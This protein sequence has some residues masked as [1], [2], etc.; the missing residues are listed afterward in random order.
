[1]NDKI[2][3]PSIGSASIRQVYAEEGVENNKDIPLPFDMLDDLHACISADRKK[4]ALA[5]AVKY[6]NNPSSNYNLELVF[7]SKS[8]NE[9]DDRYNDFIDLRPSDKKTLALLQSRGY[10]KYFLYD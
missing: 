1:M 5:E 2:T 6:V 8:Q 7:S 10:G 9:Q 3:F 4:L